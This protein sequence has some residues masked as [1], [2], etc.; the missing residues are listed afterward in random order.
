MLVK[1][2]SL[3][4]CG[5][6]VSFENFAGGFTRSGHPLIILPDVY[7]WFE[8]LETEL[9]LLLKYYCHIIPRT[10]QVSTQSISGHHSLRLALAFMV[11]LGQESNH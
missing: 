11:T 9:N 5:H 4:I 7:K 8:V 10:E 1:A 3:I 2:R 6:F